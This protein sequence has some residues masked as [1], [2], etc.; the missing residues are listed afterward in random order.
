MPVIVVAN[1]KGGVGKSTLA[2]NIAGCLAAAGHAVMLGDVDRQQS[3]RQWLALRPPQSPAIS[4][5]DVAGNDIVKPPKGTTHVVLDTPAGLHGKRLDA[6]MRI[7][8]RILIP[9]QPSLF[10]IQATHA[11]V[12]A[13]REHRR[14][15][16]VQLGLVGMRVREH[17]RANEQLHHYLSTVPVPVVGWLR[18]TQNYVQLAARGL[19]LWDVAPSRV[20]RDLE[21]WAPLVAWVQR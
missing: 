17:T 1:P 5:W 10:D 20:E 14:A 21:Q 12:L 7:A 15:G 9:L 6:V 11:F 16:E 19:T 4:G 13:L 18:D 8:D 3:A 2:T